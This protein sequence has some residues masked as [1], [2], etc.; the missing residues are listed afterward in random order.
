MVG[1][2]VAQ[3]FVNRRFLAH[4]LKQKWLSGMERES[5]KAN[6]KLGDILTM[7]TKISEGAAANVEPLEKP[8]EG[9]VIRPMGEGEQVG[10]V[11]PVG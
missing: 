10:T 9:K 8:T 2:K 1:L 11:L 7:A 4:D 5:L 3:E 6:S